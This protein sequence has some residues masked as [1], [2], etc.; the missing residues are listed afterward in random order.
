MFLRLT[1]FCALLLSSAPS[2][3]AEII[4]L[5]NTCGPWEH[6]PANDI[7]ELPVTAHIPSTPIT[8]ILSC[9]DDTK[10]WEALKV[11]CFPETAEIEYIYRPSYN[12]IAPKPNDPN[13]IDVATNDTKRDAG[14]LETTLLSDET[15]IDQTDTPS[16]KTRE[17]LTFDFRKVGVTHVVSYYFDAKEWHHRISEPRAQL[18]QRM[19]HGNYTDITL[20]AAGKTERLSLRGSTKA[21][22]PVIETCRKVK[23]ILDKES[24]KQNLD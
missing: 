19:I 22:R 6:I 13:E 5:R 12:F 9:S 2:V 23:I 1:S 17:M 24:V 14:N 8:A 21:L 15:P 3:Q 20:L 7:P 4:D 10:V 18:F 16:I 11:M